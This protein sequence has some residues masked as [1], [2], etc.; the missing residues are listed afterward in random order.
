MFNCEQDPLSLLIELTPKLAKKRYRQSIYEAWDHK[1]GYCGDEATSLDHI[2]PR[3]KS[4]SSNRN[5]LMPACRRCNSNKASL[6]M[7]DWYSQQHFYCPSRH[8]RIKAWM[9]QEPIEI[10][11]YNVDTVLAKFAAG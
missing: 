2:V 10:F 5:N 4:G 8:T 9:S 6:N 3:F 7:E 1:C 11:A